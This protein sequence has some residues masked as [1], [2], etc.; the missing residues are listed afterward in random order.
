M[1]IHS[2]TPDF[3]PA[4]IWSTKVDKATDQRTPA[5]LLWDFAIQLIFVLMLYLQGLTNTNLLLT[6]SD[7]DSDIDQLH[8]SNHARHPPKCLCNAIQSSDEDS[9]HPSTRKPTTAGNTNINNNT[10]A[11]S[12]LLNSSS[13]NLT[14]HEHFKTHYKTL[15]RTPEEVLAK[16]MNYWTLP[17]YTHFQAPPA[18]NTAGSDVH[19]IFFCKITLD[20][21]EKDNN[22]PNDEDPLAAEVEASDTLAVDDVVAGAELDGCPNPLGVPDAALGQMAITKLRQLTIKIF[23]SPTLSE[24]LKEQC[25]KTELLNGSL[26]PRPALDHLVIKEAHNQLRNAQLSQFKISQEE[27]LVLEQLS[28]MLNIIMY[29]TKQILHCDVP[30]VHEVIPYIDSVSSYFDT[31]IDNMALLPA[32]QHAALRG[33]VMMNKY[34]S[35]T[36]EIIVYRIAMILHPA[37]KTLY[38]KD[39]RWEEE[40]ISTAVSVAQKEWLENYKEKGQLL[41][42]S[43]L[44]TEDISEPHHDCFAEACRHFASMNQKAQ[45]TITNAFEEWILAA[46][47]ATQLA[48]SDPIAYW[49]GMKKAAQMALD[50]LTV[51]ATSTDVERAFS[52]GGLTVSKLCHS[53]TDKSTH[54][55]SVLGSWAKIPGFNPFDSIVEKFK[56]K[57]QRMQKKQKTTDKILDLDSD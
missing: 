40:W 39:A 9:R 3:L 18:I 13:A 56:E 20:N 57:S 22:A 42:S 15:E 17:V 46:P 16:Q 43:T 41:V 37:Y 49:L 47:I 21:S 27:W 7:S 11:P 8:R 19:Y 36:D 12:A 52:R 54:C 51:P 26:K 50:Y 29:T 14:R 24:D 2:T 10:P 30:L 48:T 38:F 31:V 53:L 1:V 4:K 32:V 23:W 35:K 34:Y 6:M 33:L 44:S 5:C 45:P 28:P 55:S 25:N